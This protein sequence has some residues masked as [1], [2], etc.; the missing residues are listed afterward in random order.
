MSGLVPTGG[1]A[2]LIA[3]VGL[4]VSCSVIGGTTDAPEPKAG[5]VADGRHFDLTI[6][7]CPEQAGGYALAEI[8]NDH[9]TTLSYRIE[10]PFIDKSNTLLEVLD[11]TAPELEPQEAA[12]VEIGPAP[13][14][15]A[16]CDGAANIVYYD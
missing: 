15:T 8:R 14:G 2:A 11:G 3:S 12:L 4:V 7:E 1:R 6:F 10:L 13:E 16:D 9:E 5:A